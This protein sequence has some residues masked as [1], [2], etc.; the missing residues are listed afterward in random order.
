MSKRNKS[1]LTLRG[2]I[3]GIDNIIVCVCLG[4][5]KQRETAQQWKKNNNAKMS[6]ALAAKLLNHG[7]SLGFRWVGEMINT[8]ELIL[9]GK[10]YKTRPK[11]G[12]ESG[13]GPIR[14]EGLIGL[15]TDGILIE[16]RTQADQLSSESDRSKYYFILS[17]GP[18]FLHVL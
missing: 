6:D 5:G 8:N 10:G 16:R 9:K 17:F 13:K 2:N 12:E 3:D 4:I 18:C 1:E 11:N 7:C 15:D 14:L